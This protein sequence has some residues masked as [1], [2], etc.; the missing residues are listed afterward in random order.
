MLFTRILFLSLLISI[1]GQTT[2]LGQI[3]SAPVSDETRMDS[4]K[5]TPST[6]QPRSLTTLSRV[7]ESDSLLARRTF[8]S[9]IVFE[10]GSRLNPRSVVGVMEEIP[11]AQTIYLRS[12]LLKPVGPLLIASGLVIGYIGVKGTQKTAY[13]KGIG[14]PAN[15]SPPDVLVDYT[16]RSLPMLAGGVGLVIGGLC[17]IEIANGLTA[18]SIDI[19]N[20]RIVPRRSTSGLQ[21]ARIGLTSSGNL[22][23]EARF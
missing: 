4:Q 8:F 20:A 23:V 1:N 15:P 10:Q 13:A 7:G 16:S 6:K 14:T 22:G 18:K 2:V 17:L 19:Y 9:T 3:I 11:Q 5:Q 12:Q 21:K